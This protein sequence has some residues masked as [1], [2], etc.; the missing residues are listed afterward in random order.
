MSGVG[1]RW[2]MPQ[3]G[4][5]Q[6]HIDRMLHMDKHGLLD[7]VGAE[8]ESQVRRRISAE[9]T[10]PDGKPWAAWSP[11]YAK[12]RH[13]GQSLLQS[14]GHLLDS[15]T[16][17]VAVDGSFVDVGSN[18]VYA[19]IQNCGGAKVGK[20]NLPARPYLGFSDDNQDDLRGVIVKWLEENWMRGG[21]PA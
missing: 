18:L 4:A 5:L 14:E 9:K 10:A 7:A 11:Q 15:I 16:Y 3:A 19:A 12:T 2:E 1:L 8:V 17:V 21:L 13:A 20:P 6:Q